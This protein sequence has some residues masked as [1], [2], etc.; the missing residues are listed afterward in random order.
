MTADPFRPI[1][2]AFGRFATGVVLAGCAR[3]D[4]APVI[5]TVNSFTSVSLSP[6]LVLWC[7]E[8]RASTFAAFMAAQSYS[9]N[10]LRADQ[11]ALSERYARHAPDPLPADA[12]EHWTT[13]AP[14]LKDALAAFD[15]KV[16]DRHGAG[17]HVVLIAEVV[18]FR[19]ADGAPLL[20]YASR[21][22][23]GPESQG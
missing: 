12:V 21:Y 9:I 8:R 7:L 20:Y 10:V 18:R 14:I 17:D 19:S 5:I 11:K 22:A 4:G 23:A 2:T 13:G 16:V 15:C 6:P 1:K 3:A